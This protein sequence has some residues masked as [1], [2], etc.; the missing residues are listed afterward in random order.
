MPHTRHTCATHAPVC[1]DAFAHT[2][3]HAPPLDR[4]PCRRLLTVKPDAVAGG[5]G[6][7]L[8]LPPLFTPP[9]MRPLRSTSSSLSSSS[10]V[11]P[12]TRCRRWRLWS[13]AP[14]PPSTPFVHVSMHAPP[15]PPS[16]DRH[17][18]RQ[19]LALQPDAVS[20]SHGYQP[21]QDALQHHL[22]Q[23]FG[24]GLL[25]VAH[26]D[27]PRTSDA[28]DLPVDVRTGAV[29]REH[30]AELVRA[31]EGMS[32][33]GV[34]KGEG[35]KHALVLSTENIMQDRLVCRKGGGG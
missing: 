35:S 24:H 3:T 27:R 12:L 20:G 18:R 6:H 2:S 30:H 32:S 26:R 31:Q 13:Q 28:A 33:A 34:R 1:S 10:S 9:H 23:P 11:C 21:L 16:P 8:I 29:D 5:R 25:G 15:L 19:L 7:P 17:P 14:P 22:L 4:H